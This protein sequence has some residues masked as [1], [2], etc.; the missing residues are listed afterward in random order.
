MT[1]GQGE[2]IVLDEFGYAYPGGADALHGVSLTILPGESVCIAG[3]N[4]AG[5]ST[6]LLACAG[7]LRGSGDIRV[8]GRAPEVNRA[9]GLVFQNPDDQLFC[10]DILSDIAFG[11]AN[12]KLPHA[13]IARRAA[14]AIKTAGLSGLEH[15]PPHRLSGGERKRA[16]IAAVLACQP[17]ILALDE[18]WANLDAPGARMVSGLIRDF[19]GTRLIA[20]HELHLAAEVCQRLIILDHGAVVADGPLP[21]LLARR[22]LLAAHGLDFGLR[23]LHCPHQR[24]DDDKKPHESMARV[25]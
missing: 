22:D 4:G 1:Q 13:E 24:T 8:G 10:T 9:C 14:E 11:P 3:P 15:R 23:C 17:S 12:Q 18:P 7:L 5:K 2:A 16:A 25:N 19:P 21:Q 6:L 20:S